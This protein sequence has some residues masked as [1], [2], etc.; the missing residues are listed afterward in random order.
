MNIKTQLH[1][2][3]CSSIV[4]ILA[5]LIVAS[6]LVTISYVTRAEKERKM[7]CRMVN[8]SIKCRR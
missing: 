7:S 3:L 1:N 2:F 5:S 8:E 6:M 4:V